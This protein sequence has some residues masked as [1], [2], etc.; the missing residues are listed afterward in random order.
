MV[1]CEFLEKFSL[2]S[3][4]SAPHTAVILTPDRSF[5]IYEQYTMAIKKVTI[6][7]QEVSF[8]IDIFRYVS[9]AY[10]ILYGLDF[11]PATI[12]CEK[13]YSFVDSRTFFD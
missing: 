7:F 8:D 4:V 6:N 9:S 3:E 10:P 5:N 1:I 13:Y 12:Q 2:V 11:N